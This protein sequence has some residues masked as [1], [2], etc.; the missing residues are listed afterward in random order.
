MDNL[1]DNIRPPDDIVREQLLE[2][3]RSEFEKQIDEAIYLSMQEAKQQRDL[4]KEFEDRLINEYT[5]EKNRR[6]ELFKDF[7]FNLQKIGKFDKE[8]KDVFDI[9]E[10]IIDLYCRQILETCELDETTYNNI[11]NTLQKV[12][13]QSAVSL[14]KSI[15]IKI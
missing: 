2:D 10:N 13:N 11:F 5:T 7:L 15:I 1:E 3:T 14:L 4:Q 12:R 8:V 6:T 9:L